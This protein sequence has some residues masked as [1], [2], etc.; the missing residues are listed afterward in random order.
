MPELE[1][2]FRLATNKVKPDP[3]ALERQHRRQRSSS[4]TGRASAYVAVAAIIVVVVIG[5]YLV[6]AS[7]SNSVVP[8]DS[9]APSPF[10][11]GS[12]MTIQTT[13]VVD[14]SGDTVRT[15]SGLPSDAFGLD[16]EPGGSRVAYSSMLFLDGVN[17]IDTRAA[18]GTDSRYLRTEGITATAP[19]WSPDG[20]L[21]AFEGTDQGGNTDIY[22]I[23]A[24][25]SG[26]RRLTTDPAVDQFPR[27]SPDGATVIYD[28]TGARPHQPDPQ[29]SATAEIWSVRVSGGAPQRLTDNHVP[30]N[31]P[32]YS[33]QGDRI[34]YFHDAQ[35]W[36]MTPTG[37]DQKMLIADGGFTPRWSP[38]GTK[39]AFTVYDPS[40]RPQVDRGSGT[41]DAPLITLV[42]Y[43]IRTGV[44][45]DL[46][47]V[48]MASDF[49]APVWLSDT[50]LL[51]RRV[52]TSQP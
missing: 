26:L 32:S 37:G 42:L 9:G 33:P 12:G 8:G 2:V 14:L 19:A 44:R 22:M 27:W 23:G 17:Q 11:P 31:A 10:V 5:A 16:V 50:Q 49:N 24:D 43:D 20:S 4:R 34:V 1:E 46:P 52:P 30:D 18:D 39:I 7:N 40:F 21:I 6:R 3:N 15:I 28:N 51:I 38:D 47:N 48:G 35:L 25:G 45:T 13:E 29:F 36:T 41:F